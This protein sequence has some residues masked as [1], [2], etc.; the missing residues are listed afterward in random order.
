MMCVPKNICTISCRYISRPHSCQHPFSRATAH[1]NCALNW[2]T[3]SCARVWLRFS[4]SRLESNARS[5]TYVFRMNCNKKKNFP[6]HSRDEPHSP[7]YLIRFPHDF[8]STIFD[9]RAN[10]HS[11]YMRVQFNKFPKI[12]FTR[13]VYI[14]FPFAPLSL[15]SSTVHVAG[16]PFY[17]GMRFAGGGG[18]NSNLW[19]RCHIDLT[20]YPINDSHEGNELFVSHA[21]NNNNRFTS[22]TSYS[23]CERQSPIIFKK[24]MAPTDVM[25]TNIFYSLD[26][27]NNQSNSP[28][29]IDRSINH[30]HI[31]VDFVRRHSF[32]L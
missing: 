7:I 23:W 11:F 19:L 18:G 28:Q 17:S 13:C 9:S 8:A 14:S 15:R 12:P 27:N 31:H 16:L 25:R 3:S 6:P 30:F 10:R 24:K 32:A 4:S 20:H 26:C 21:F 29:S 2:C 1:I 5:R 22:I